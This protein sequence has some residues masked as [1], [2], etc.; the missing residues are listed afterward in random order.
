MHCGRVR[1]I[2]SWHFRHDLYEYTGSRDFHFIKNYVDMSV[3]PLS[4][5]PSHASSIDQ[6]IVSRSIF[7]N[8]FIARLLFLEL[9]NYRDGTW[10]FAFGS[11]HFDTETCRQISLAF[12]F[13]RAVFG[14]S[15]LT[16]TKTKYKKDNEYQYFVSSLVLY[17]K[18]YKKKFFFLVTWKCFYFTYILYFLT[19]IVT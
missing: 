3:F 13:E 4:L 17:F 1:Y 7:Y 5:F 14:L 10:L 15:V 12:E 18:L 16:L 9:L 2:I 19:S 11:C 8:N 6:K